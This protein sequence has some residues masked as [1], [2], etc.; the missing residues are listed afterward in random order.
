MKKTAITFR[1]LV[2]LTFT[3]ISMIG[4]KTSALQ[5]NPMDSQK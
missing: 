4:L 5:S 3:V 1:T 2:V